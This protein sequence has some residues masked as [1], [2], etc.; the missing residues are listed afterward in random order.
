MTYLASARIDTATYW[1]RSGVDSAGDA[2]FD[3]PTTISVRW[4]SQEVVLRSADGSE[5]RVDHTVYLGQDVAI[6][7]FLYLGT[8]V[9]ASPYNQTGA[10]EVQDFSKTKALN[11]QKITRKAV[12]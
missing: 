1:A 10:L 4:V 5:R 12:L 11:G 3:A 2:E 7:D 6:G 9:V 8:S